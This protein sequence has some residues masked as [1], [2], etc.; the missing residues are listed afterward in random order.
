MF[1]GHVNDLQDNEWRVYPQLNEWALS[2]SDGKYFLI[3]NIC[4]HQGSFFKDT[5][6]KNIRRCPYHGWSFRHTGEPIGSGTTEHI[7]KN[8]ENLKTK[9]V[10]IWNGFIF[11]EPHDLPESFINTDNLKLV[12]HRVD[13]VMSN[14]K[15]IVHLFLDVDH[16]P[17]VH[18]KVYNQ[19]VS[20]EIIWSIHDSSSL[21]LVPANNEFSSNYTESFL[22]QDKNLPYG[23]AWFTV[24]PYTMM[25]WQPGAWFITTAI[26]TSQGTT[27]V[28]VYKYRDMNYSDANWKLNEE[29]WETAW[30]QDCT[31]SEMIVLNA[32][33]KHLEQPKVH[34]NEW[35]KRNRL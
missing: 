20:E 15:N 9:E 14:F 12:E 22:P 17:V 13:T 24:Y 8:T 26:P 19:L 33:Q 5:Q 35:L 6:G 31:Q 21:Q 4:P 7:C 10:Y 11:S 32:E 16:I 25:E 3:S 34:Y 1:L 28:S 30:S 23:A 18:P 2:K 29:I 27:D